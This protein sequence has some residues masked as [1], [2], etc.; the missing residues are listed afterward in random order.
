LLVCP[1]RADAANSGSW[2]AT[3]NPASILTNARTTTTTDDNNNWNAGANWNG[4]LPNNG[5]ATFNS[6]NGDN[7]NCQITPYF[8]VPT[9]TSVPTNGGTGSYSGTLYI[10]GVLPV[11]N[12]NSG[13][14]L[15]NT[16]TITAKVR[17]GQKLQFNRNLSINTASVTHDA[18]YNGGVIELPNNGTSDRTITITTGEYL[19]RVEHATTAHNMILGSNVSVGSYI[20]TAATGQTQALN[21]NGNT[22]FVVQALAAPGGQ[23]TS[24]TATGTGS[25]DNGQHFYKWSLIAPSGEGPLGPSGASTISASPSGTQ[26]VD[27]VV[28]SVADANCV[29]VKLYRTKVGG[30]SSTGPWFYVGTVWSTAG[31]TYRDTL[32]DATLTVSDLSEWGL[33]TKNNVTGTG[34]V[35]FS[36]KNPAGAAQAT[37]LTQLNWQDE[38]GGQDFQ[39][40]TI[41]GAT[42]QLGSDV[43]CESLTVLSTGTLILNGHR[44]IIKGKKGSISTPDLDV[45]GTVNGLTGGSG[46]DFSPTVAGTQFWRDTRTSGIGGINL[47]G[48]GSGAGVPAVQIIAG[49]SPNTVQ[50]ASGSIVRAVST[51]GDPA[52]RAGTTN[53][54][55]LNGAT[56]IIDGTAS[57]PQRLGGGNYTDGGNGSAGNGT[58]SAVTYT[59]NISGGGAVNAIRCKLG[60]GGSEINGATDITLAPTA[61]ASGGQ[62]YVLDQPAVNCQT[63]TLTSP[64]A[65][66]VTLDLSQNHEGT[67]TPPRISVSGVSRRPA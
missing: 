41:D 50:L 37:L 60:N 38:K 51:G 10:N 21:L 6:A 48:T 17:I 35:T 65:N 31:A 54:F 20:Q 29:G 12:G 1:S 63:M 27:I 40:V 42:V 55:S 34:G 49:A 52:F 58:R 19:G 18:L 36:N 43:T 8:S 39:A 16:N 33:H 23:L 24:A 30:S 13:D 3:G 5:T 25:I 46:I 57:D 56:L 32:A 66:V 7:G 45:A 44:V 15:W 11:T 61:L 22:L 28:P 62:I 47:Y 26:A 53:I 2:Q 4:G 64:N 9:P 67:Q 59:G 14:F